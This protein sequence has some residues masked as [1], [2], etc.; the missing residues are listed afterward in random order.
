MGSAWAGM[1]TSADANS[2]TGRQAE[3]RLKALLPQLSGEDAPQAAGKIV[4]SW[5][6]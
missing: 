3:L 4:Q 5:T 1:E 2:E 6:H